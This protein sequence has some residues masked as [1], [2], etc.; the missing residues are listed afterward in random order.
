VSKKVIIIESDLNIDVNLNSVIILWNKSKHEN[1]NFFSL[2]L[3]V[4]E[5]AEFYK[6]K[7]LEWISA[8]SRS[9]VNSK[10]LEAYYEINKGLSFFL[11]NL[12]RAKM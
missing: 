7:F 1:S 3:F 6:T 4:E 2:P 5:N 12:I 9:K 10:N 11:V 8:L